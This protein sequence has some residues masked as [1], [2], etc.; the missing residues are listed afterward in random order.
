MFP[1]DPTLV[2]LLK[3]FVVA[4]CVAF[5]AQVIYNA[6]MGRYIRR[7]HYRYRDEAPP[8]DAPRS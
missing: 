8:T 3:F 7:R 4:T 5:W 6:L 1:L 2:W